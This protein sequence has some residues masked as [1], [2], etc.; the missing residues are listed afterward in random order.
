MRL[1]ARALPPG[2]VKAV[3]EEK[4]APRVHR[5]A[6]QAV[7]IRRAREAQVSVDPVGRHGE[8]GLVLRQRLLQALHLD[9]D[10]QQVAVDRVHDQLRHEPC[11][12]RRRACSE[13]RAWART[14]VQ[15]LQ[16]DTQRACVAHRERLA[17]RIV[18]LHADGHALRERVEPVAGEGVGDDGVLQA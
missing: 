2:L 17:V 14:R 13:Q 3:E 9:E 12:A 11:L 8:R 18:P 10:R 6:Q 4:G 15:A 16:Q 5:G 1:N 7:V